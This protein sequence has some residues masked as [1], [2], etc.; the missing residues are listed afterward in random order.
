M[1][2]VRFTMMRGI[3]YNSVLLE[4][5]WWK[6]TYEIAFA[7]IIFANGGWSV[8]QGTSAPTQ[9]GDIMNYLCD[10][11]SNKLETHYD[12]ILEETYV[13]VFMNCVD[14][15]LHESRISVDGDAIKSLLT[16]VNMT[17]AALLK[18]DKK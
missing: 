4:R 16:A 12:P 6:N 9:K 13:K 1:G 14:K 18:G 2:V 15:Y 10:E 17:Y 7:T 8:S 3:F 5:G 11:C